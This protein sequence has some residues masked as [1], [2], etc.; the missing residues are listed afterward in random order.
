MTERRRNLFDNV[1]KL[2]LHFSCKHYICIDLRIHCD[3]EGPQQ[4]S[5]PGA[6]KSPSTAFCLLLRLFTLRCTEK[7]MHLMLE[8]V[9][10]FRSES[11]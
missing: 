4:A 1:E 3:Y 8:H 2:L 6:Q 7:Q 9:G 11:D 10:R 5:S